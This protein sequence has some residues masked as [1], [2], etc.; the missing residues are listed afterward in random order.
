MG[1]PL[2]STSGQNNLHKSTGKSELMGCSKDCPHCKESIV[3][4]STHTNFENSN[5]YG[6]FVIVEK[7]NYNQ[8]KLR[9]LFRVQL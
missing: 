4:L 2:S 7:Q 1:A 9:L 5:S 3:R 6:R 8:P